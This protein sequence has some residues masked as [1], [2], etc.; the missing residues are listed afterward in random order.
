MLSLT[1]SEVL[2]FSSP[3]NGSVTV[4]ER[5]FRKGN[6]FDAKRAETVVTGHVFSGETG[7]RAGSEQLPEYFLCLNATSVGIKKNPRVTKLLFAQQV[8]RI[9]MQCPSHRAEDRKC[10]REHHGK[11]NRGKHKWILGGRL[12][13][14]GG[15]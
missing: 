15:E 13:D 6:A 10:S 3:P 14:D 9:D 1:L 2:I 12:V 4:V 5:Y 8:S 11:C 7:R